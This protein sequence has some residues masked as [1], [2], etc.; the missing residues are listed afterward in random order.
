MVFIFTVVLE[1]LQADADAFGVA[2]K[3]WQSH[4]KSYANIVGLQV[5]TQTEFCSQIEPASM[6]F[7]C[8]ADPCNSRYDFLHMVLPKRWESPVI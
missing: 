4:V 8:N 2:V 6:V 3:T 7:A 5:K 1:Y